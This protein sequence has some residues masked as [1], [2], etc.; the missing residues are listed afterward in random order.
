[1]AI[2]TKSAVYPAIATETG[3]MAKA[4]TLLPQMKSK[5]PA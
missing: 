1:M 4:G 2:Q 5:F 3:I